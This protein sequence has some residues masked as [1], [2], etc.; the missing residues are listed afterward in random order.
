MSVHRG[1]VPAREIAGARALDLDDPRTE[2][3]KLACGK[4]R[5]NG[6]LERKDGA[7]VQRQHCQKYQS[8]R[9]LDV[10]ILTETTAQLLVE[11]NYRIPPDILAAL[12]RA[13]AEEESELGRQTLEHLVHNYEV[14]AAE[15]L[16]VCQDSGVTV[17]LLE[18]G[19]DVHWTGGNL[20]EAIFDGIRRG[21]RSGYLRGP[22]SAIR[23]RGAIRVAR[24]RASSTTTS[25]PAMA[26][27]SPSRRRGSAPRT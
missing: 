9:D 10:Q 5:R 21:T 1:V 18:V 23:W 7:A 6:L 13:A 8:M 14:A 19:Q 27:G 17:V 24:R 2:V 11:A 22:S 20:Q 12:R 16:P 26:F 15:R 4:R 25:W 3:R